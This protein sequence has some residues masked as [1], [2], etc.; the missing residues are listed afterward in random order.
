[1]RIPRILWI[2]PGLLA[3]LAAPAGAEDPAAEVPAV[4]VPHP[5]GSDVLAQVEPHRA[6]ASWLDAHLDHVRLNKRSGFAY[7]RAIDHG[8]RGLL[9][10]VQGPRVGSKRAVGLGFEL[11][12]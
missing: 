11:R 12:F 6:D 10:S 4:A 8:D 1:M 7:T 5:S 9:W 2:L 3:C